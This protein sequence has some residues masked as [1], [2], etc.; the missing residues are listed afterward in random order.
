ML[1]LALHSVLLVGAVAYMLG[2]LS[3]G[4]GLVLLARAV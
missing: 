1:L 3:A 4:L 2:W